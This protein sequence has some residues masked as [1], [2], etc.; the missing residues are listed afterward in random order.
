MKSHHIYDFQSIQSTRNSNDE[1]LQE[2]DSQPGQ[3]S[4]IEIMMKENIFIAM[5]N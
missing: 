3:N 2:M 1:N 4:F 5:I